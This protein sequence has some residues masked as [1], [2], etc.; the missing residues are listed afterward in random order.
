MPCG[1]PD[2]AAAQVAGSLLK[3]SQQGP[4]DAAAADGR[5]NPHAPYL[6]G[7]LVEPTYGP[8][9]H[10]AAAEVSDEERSMWW[11]ELLL[12]DTN[13]LFDL[14]ATRKPGIPKIRGLRPYANGWWLSM[15]SLTAVS[16]RSMDLA[17]SCNEQRLGN[18]LHRSLMLTGPHGIYRLRWMRSAPWS[19]SQ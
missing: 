11:N 14:E 13:G 12:G 16:R 6:C 8:A 10:R 9:A 4:A 18:R 7:R 15:T 3:R 5:V 1:Q 2:N 19:A 17:P